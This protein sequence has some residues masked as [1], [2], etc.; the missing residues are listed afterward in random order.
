MAPPRMEPTHSGRQGHSAAGWV[1]V[2]LKIG[3]GGE[4]QQVRGNC[5]ENRLPAIRKTPI[6]FLKTSAMFDKSFD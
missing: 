3:V 4:S 6:S 1:W 2:L 5:S